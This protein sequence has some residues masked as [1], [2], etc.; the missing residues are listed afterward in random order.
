MSKITMSA[1]VFSQYSCTSATLPSPM[2]VRGSGEGRFCKT[3]PTASPPAVSTSADSS[4]ML[5]SVALSSL[6]TGEFS[7]TSTT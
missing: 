1:P 3:M 6:R 4:S 2:K 7:P 5:S